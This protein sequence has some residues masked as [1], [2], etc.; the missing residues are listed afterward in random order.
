M[1]KRRYRINIRLTFFVFL[2]LFLSNLMIVALLV[3]LYLLGVISEFHAAPLLVGILSLA[4]SLLVSTVGY[5]FFCPVLF[6]PAERADCGY[7]ACGVRRFF[8]AGKRAA[9]RV[10]SGG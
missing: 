3:L 4:A 8:R 6:P 2:I 10:R 5:G 7:Q 1:K 9:G